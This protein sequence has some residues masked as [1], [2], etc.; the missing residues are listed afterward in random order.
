MCNK[1]GSN[2]WP[3]WISDPLTDEQVFR[4][5]LANPGLIK[6]DVKHTERPKPTD[7]FSLGRAAWINRQRRDPPPEL[8][9]EKRQEWLDGWDFEA[10]AEE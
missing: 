10:Y 4:L 6:N 2:E 5:N 3:R 1:S 7:P 8:P 9:P